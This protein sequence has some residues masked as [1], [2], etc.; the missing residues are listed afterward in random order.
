MTVATKKD[1]TI[2]LDDRSFKIRLFNLRQ[3]REL[4]IVVARGNEMRR[5]QDAA[6]IPED[7]AAIIEAKGNAEGEAYDYFV[8]ILATALG[9]DHP[10]M[11]DEAIFDLEITLSDLRA[12]T[13]KVLTF[14]GYAPVGER[15]A[16][17]KS[18][19]DGS[20]AI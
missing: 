1:I 7:P 9:R 19:G 6:P 18:T 14:A 20:M 17:A 3:H 5:Q 15:K 4:G 8:S 11:T 2:V 10:T 13:E 16:A 12:E